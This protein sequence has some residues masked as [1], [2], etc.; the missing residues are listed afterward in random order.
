M[1]PAFPTTH[2]AQIPD[3][4]DSARWL[5]HSIWPE[6]AV[7]LLFGAPKLGKTWLSLDLALSVSSGTSCLDAFTVERPGPALVY[8]AEDS[9]QSARA[10]VEGLCRHRG[11]GL[12]RA[13][14]HFI[15]APSL[16]LDHED[17]SH[18]LLATVEKLQPRLLLLDPF[19]RLHGQDENDSGAVSAILA[20]LRQL[21]RDRNVAI[22]LVHHTRKTGG[23]PQGYALRGSGDLYA[24][25]DAYACLTRRDH[26]L[27]LSLEHRCH[28]P[29]EPITLGLVSRPD[30]SC[31]H[32]EIS[33]AAPVA[34]SGALD[35]SVL[36][37]LAATK[38]PLRR[39]HL[40]ARLRVN[41]HRLGATLESL[42][43]R[44]H[45]RRQAG[46]WVAVP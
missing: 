30:G 28:P 26:G 35:Q 23:G 13:D 21:Q 46:G 15:T 22:C 2:V 33:Q 9:L 16:R 19:V 39:T 36:T 5:V 32:L 29:R 6:S 18:R 31:T 44:G 3:K 34:T 4:A 42:E 27:R 20:S 43:Q 38:T 11:I 24:W 41:N 45:V 14:L 17:D 7:G 8:L 40:R 12:H 25:G 37:E 1:T 10:R